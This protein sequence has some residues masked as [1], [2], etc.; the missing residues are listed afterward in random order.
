[1][2]SPPHP[3]FDSLS[4][5]ATDAAGVVSALKREVDTIVKSQLDKAVGSLDLVSREEYEVLKDMV[6]RLS[7]EN[8]A[9]A[10]RVQALEA[11]ETRK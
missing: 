5:L 4:A 11:A 1:M 8:E 6:Q 3:I 9:L 10:E 7:Q 2:S